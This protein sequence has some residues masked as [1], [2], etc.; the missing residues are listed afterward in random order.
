MFCVRTSIK[1]VVVLLQIHLELEV[2][3][4]KVSNTLQ[5]LYKLS[6]NRSPGTLSSWAFH[7]SKA[8]VFC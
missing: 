8:V 3:K 1:E 5:C 2:P 6:L 7:T 4:V